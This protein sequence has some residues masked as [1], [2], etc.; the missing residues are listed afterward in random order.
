[1]RRYFPRH[2]SPALGPTQPSTVDMGVSF[3][4]AKCPGCGV[5]SPSPLN[6]KIKGRF[7]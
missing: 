1:M 6:A 2:S 5:D 7:L 4:G 3:P